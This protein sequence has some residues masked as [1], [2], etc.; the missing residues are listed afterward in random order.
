[1]LFSCEGFQA[2]ISRLGA[3]LGQHYQGIPTASMNTAKELP[4]STSPVFAPSAISFS[5]RKSLRIWIKKCSRILEFAPEKDK[6]KF[7]MED[8]S[9]SSPSRDNRTDAKTLLS[10]ILL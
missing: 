6:T 1:M 5:D 4:S 3:E 10:Q 8:V 2:G 7:A 9:K